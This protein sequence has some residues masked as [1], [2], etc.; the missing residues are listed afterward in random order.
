MKIGEIQDGLEALGNN[1]RIVSETANAIEASL[2]EEI[3]SVDQIRWAFIGIVRSIDK[4]AQDTEELV[5]GT[6]EVQEVLSKL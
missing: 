4:A 2:C 1:L 6:I 3:L 5:N